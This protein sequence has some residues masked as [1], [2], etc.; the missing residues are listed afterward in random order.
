MKNYEESSLTCHI[1]VIDYSHPTVLREFFD[2]I[3]DE[4]YEKLVENDNTLEIK[5]KKKIK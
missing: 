5:L 1:G 4:E 3:D 2:F